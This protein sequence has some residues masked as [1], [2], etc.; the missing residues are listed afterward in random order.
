M[1]TYELAV[2]GERDV[3]L[4]FRTVGVQTFAV[5]TPA[6]ATETL[7]MLAKSAKYAVIFVT[8][9][10]AEG[11][12]PVIQEYTTQALPSIVLVPGPQGSQ[13]F[14]LE[15]IRRIVEKA[16]GADILFGKEGR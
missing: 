2:I 1:S 8:E 6:E 4:G 7:H 14:A 13:G 12:L 15:R 10:V 9:T 3:V 16:V 5:A 11:I